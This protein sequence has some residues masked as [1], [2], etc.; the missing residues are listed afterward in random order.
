[1]KG[2]YTSFQR[3]GRVF[4]L[5][6]SVLNKYPRTKKNAHDPQGYYEEP[7]S[8]PA[9]PEKATKGDCHDNYGCDSIGISEWFNEAGR[10]K[11]GEYVDQFH[12][13]SFEPENF[14]D[15]YKDYY[16]IAQENIPLCSFGN[17]E[18]ITKD[19]P[20]GTKATTYPKGPGF[21][22][23]YGNRPVDG[24]DEPKAEISKHNDKNPYRMLVNFD[25]PAETFHEIVS[26]TKEI[27]VSGS[28]SLKC[29]H[30]TKE[31]ETTASPT[32][33]YRKYLYK[34]SCPPTCTEPEAKTSEYSCNV[35]SK[36][37]VLNQSV[38]GDINL[39]LKRFKEYT[40]LSDK[41]PVELDVS[42]NLFLASKDFVL[43]KNYSCDAYPEDIDQY[44][45]PRD[46]NMVKLI[47]TASPKT[48]FDSGCLTTPFM[49][50]SHYNYKIAESDILDTTASTTCEDPVG[51]IL[52]ITGLHGERN[53][54][55]GGNGS[56]LGFDVPAGGGPSLQFEFNEG[57]FFPV[58]VAGE[59]E[60]W[61]L[62]K[63][64]PKDENK[65]QWKDVY[66]TTTCPPLYD[67]ALP[68]KEYFLNPEVFS[69]VDAE[70]RT[71]Q[72]D[73]SG[74]CTSLLYGLSFCNG[75]PCDDMYKGYIDCNGVFVSTSP[76]GCAPNPC[77]DKYDP[78]KMGH[79]IHKDTEAPATEGFCP[80]LESRCCPF[81]TKDKDGSKFIH[82]FRIS[83]NLGR[84]IDNAPSPRAIVPIYDLS[85]NP[86]NI[87]VAY[88][89]DISCSPSVSGGWAEASF[90]LSEDGDEPPVAKTYK[91]S[92][93]SFAS[94]EIK[95]VGDFTMAYGEWSRVFDVY[96]I[97]GNQIGALQE[98]S[99][100]DKF[101]YA[102][103][104][105]CDNY[106]KLIDCE[107]VDSSVV[108]SC[109]GCGSDPCMECND[110]Q[111]NCGCNIEDRALPTP[112]AGKLLC[113]QSA[114]GGYCGRS[115]PEQSCNGCF[116]YSSYEECGGNTPRPRIRCGA[117]PCCDPN[118]KNQ[119]PY[120]ECLPLPDCPPLPAAEPSSILCPGLEIYNLVTKT[121]IKTNLRVEFVPFTEFEE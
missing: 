87:K 80:Q 110:K 117:P 75:T 99:V 34:N 22:E 51:G 24:F 56:G 77:A 108:I 114:I 63:L 109:A 97:I 26:R 40:K 95:K 62:Y 107:L 8:V 59:V 45:D 7:P 3:F 85:K 121:E 102:E 12:P 65:N 13:E 32:S 28:L 55:G 93:N 73:V 111:R 47:K 74:T 10:F 5:S 1:M 100:Y 42:R 15:K 61:R 19:Y 50:A 104:S 96:T 69:K 82:S 27:K 57:A 29:I 101:D 90:F 9:G 78:D 36:I 30:E 20:D 54:F 2:R 6:S 18:E 70:T 88:A 105:R 64:T 52:S 38:E 53:G 115:P 94:Y 37:E 89:Y 116:S 118:G 72:T 4:G 21:H 76:C 120:C 113:I 16:P 81:T 41:E 66:K 39:T 49:N 46:F 91:P 71:M 103:G 25:M 48:K 86:D 83:G 14:G 98:I 92:D 17:H 33:Y 23:M 31:G 68:T 119:D 106:G 67:W 43:F 11:K 84:Y 35:S 79:A 44:P 60:N 112:I 58:N